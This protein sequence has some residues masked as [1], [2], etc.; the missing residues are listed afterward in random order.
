[1]WER[2]TAKG[3]EGGSQNSKLKSGFKNKEAI[4]K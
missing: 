1:M 4:L 3:V 2:E